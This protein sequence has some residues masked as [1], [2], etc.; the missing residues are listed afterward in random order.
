MSGD[1]ILYVEDDTLSREVMALVIDDLPQ[2]ELVMFSDSSDFLARVDALSVVPRLIL[3][4]IHVQPITGFAMLEL[5][6]ASPHYRSVR[7]V[8]LTASVMSEEVLKLRKIGFDGAIA[9]PID[10]DIFPQHIEQVLEGKSIW[11]IDSH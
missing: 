2:Y 8:A 5:L 3:L 10:Q 4:D 11:I 1:L 7:I 6:R 9:K